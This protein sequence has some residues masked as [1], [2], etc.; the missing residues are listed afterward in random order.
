MHTWCVRISIPKLY[1]CVYGTV[2]DIR[3]FIIFYFITLSEIRIAMITWR[4]NPFPNENLTNIYLIDLFP[5]K[6]YF[7][8]IMFTYS[9]HK[10]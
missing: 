8:I 9:V 6:I 4:V 7:N 1:V 2:L 3:I 10:Y 5:W